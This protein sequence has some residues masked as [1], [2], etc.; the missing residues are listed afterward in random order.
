MFDFCFGSTEQKIKG[1][2][3]RRCTSGL[4]LESKVKTRDTRLVIIPGAV[5]LEAVEADLVT[6]ARNG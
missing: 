5:A 4:A 3:S 6:K 2:A 1:R